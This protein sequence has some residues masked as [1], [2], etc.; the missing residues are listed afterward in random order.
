[1]LRRLIPSLLLT[2]LVSGISGTLK[3]QKTMR[4]TPR[5]K[6]SRSAVKVEI[7][8]TQRERAA[9]FLSRFTFGAR[10]GEV[11]KLIADGP[12]GADAWF[13]R[14]LNPS[15]IPDPELDRRLRDYPTLSMTPQQILATFPDRGTITRIA[16]GKEQYPA[17]AQLASVYQVQ[18]FKL[19]RERD[20][21]Q[22]AQADQPFSAPNAADPQKDADKATASRIAGEL[23]AMPKGQR[24]QALLKMPVEDR[25]A[26]TTYVAGQQRNTLLADFTPRE[27]EYFNCMSAGIGPTYLALN[28]L[29]QARIVRDILTER[30]L[31]AVMTDFWFNHFNIYAPKDSDQWYTTTYERD[32]IRRNALGKFSDL[33]LATAQSP[34]MMVYLDNWLSIGPN[35]PANG[36]NNPNG[37]RGNRGL[38]ENYAR[39]VMELHTLSVNGGYSQADVTSLAAV[40]T[41]W[42]IDHPE[43]AGPFVFDPKKHEP[44]AKQWLGQTIPMGEM[45]EGM[46]ALKVLAASPKTAHFIAWKLAQRFVA[47]D[48]PA[49]LVDR[50]TQTYLSTGGDIKAILHAMVQSPEFNSRK[51]FRNKVKTP[52]EFVASAFRSTGTD[53]ANPGAIVAILDKPMGMGLYRAL[54]PTG[55]FITAE[56][57]MNTD[58]L[59]DRLNF[60]LALTSGKF[61]NQRFDSSRLVA[62]GLMSQPAGTTPST[63]SAKASRVSVSMSTDH[64]RVLRNS[65]SVNSSDAAPAVDTMDVDSSGSSATAAS[66]IATGTGAELALSVLETSLVGGQV[67]LQTN[68]LILQQLHEAVTKSGNN[69]STTLDMLTALVLGAPEFQL[70]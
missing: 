68:G 10:P 40:L 47:D 45:N 65:H 49:A 16:D 17:D 55:Y 43:L 61:G 27:R 28:E 67:S 57:W 54:P 9:Q 21:K 2:V 24:M 56:K 52:V 15:A 58:A 50:M 48:P 60:A 46:T 69:S 4:F 70:R 66:A 34:A 3:A 29:A 64:A 44:G 32:S 13:E 23:F 62:M 12:Q 63:I 1:M 31:Q 18:V 11:E 26:F 41:G 6:T 35:S 36:G 39:E 37:K 8:L 53:P 51:Y 22:A 33:L 14:Q 20:M 5:Q 38:N 7:P 19:Q 25:I 42:S 30:Q 59:L